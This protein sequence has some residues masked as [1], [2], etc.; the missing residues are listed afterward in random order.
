M[1]DQLT[2]TAD[3]AA[4]A[5]YGI[6]VVDVRIKRLNLP[7][8][9][10]QSVFARMRAERERIARQYRAEGE[11]QALASVPMPTGRRKRSFRPRIKR[12]KKCAAKATRKSTRIYGQ[13]YS[14]NPQF[15]KLLR[16]LEVL[17]ESA[18]RQDHDYLQFRFG[19]VEGF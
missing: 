19:I 15:Y 16:T 6:R 4:L 1:L 2:T 7:E 8:Q 10:K 3:R 5:Q 13:A 12:P 11:Q 17:Q 18:R 14:R 9:N